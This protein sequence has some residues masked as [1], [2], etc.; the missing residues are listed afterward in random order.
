[1]ANITPTV[2][3]APNGHRNMVEV[4]WGPMASADVGL[5]VELPGFSDRSVQIQGTFGDGT[6]NMQGCDEPTPTNWHLLTDP[7]GNDIAKTANDLE[8]ITEIT[9]YTRPQF[10]GTTG[11]AMTVTM[12]ARRA[13]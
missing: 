2:N 13:L 9:R 11:S 3:Y 5:P 8:H 4:I 10:T 6:L 7:Q 12:T 1:M